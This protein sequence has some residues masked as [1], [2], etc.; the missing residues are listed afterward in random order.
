MC[1]CVCVCV[2][3]RGLLKPYHNELYECFV[4][5]SLPPSFSRLL[6]FCSVFFPHIPPTLNDDKATFPMQWHDMTKKNIT[7]KYIYLSYLNDGNTQHVYKEC[8]RT[9]VKHSNG[10]HTRLDG[11]SDLIVCVS[12]CSCACVYVDWHFQS[13]YS[14]TNS[15][16]QN[17]TRKLNSHCLAEL[18]L[19]LACI[20][21]SLLNCNENS[22]RWHILNWWH[23]CKLCIQGV[24]THQ[25]TFLI[26]LPPFSLV[27]NRSQPCSMHSFNL[28]LCAV[29]R[30]YWLLV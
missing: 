27:F 8:A 6:S 28:I 9:L 10:W 19:H 23:I 15:S 5:A 21:N 4:I 3:N 25:K 7:A 13:A 14:A 16:E 22:I 18:T 29:V 1:L 24:K 11:F 20:D 30:W 26:F 2:F 17:H 12:V